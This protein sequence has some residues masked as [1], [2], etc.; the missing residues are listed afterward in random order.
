[1]TSAKPQPMAGQTEAPDDLIAELARLM[2][3]D[4]RPEA[5]EPA[6]VRI[7]GSEAAPQAQPP[8]RIPGADQ[9]SAAPARAGDDT[10][11]F[12]FD[13]DLGA[14]R[15]PAGPVTPLPPA[16][17]MPQAPETAE[18]PADAHDSIADL[19]AAEFASDAGP[20]IEPE[21]PVAPARGEDN[22]GVPPVFGLGTP[23]PA[24]P[25]EPVIAEPVVETP[26]PAEAPQAPVERSDSLDEIER[27]VGPAVRL[28]P[29]PPSPALRSLATPTL[30]REPT[31]HQPE[32]RHP[33]HAV[34][35]AILAAAAATGAAVDYV[36]T[37]SA[38]PAAFDGDDVPP[39]AA[40]RI[41]GLSRGFAG[42]LV[43]VTLLV[44]A[45][46]GLYWVL[47]NSGGASGPAPLIVANAEPVKEV[48]EMASDEAAPQSVVFNEISGVD[49]G[50]DERIV[51]RDQADVAAVSQVAA[52][53]GGDDGLV[54]R[55]VRTVTVRPD[56][57]IVSGEEGLAGAAMLPV[58][59]PDVPDVPGA[60]FS[61][62]D[63]L[64][65]AETPAETPAATAAAP[66][67]MVPV[68][69]GSTVPAVDAAGNPIAGR[70][71]PVP[72]DKPADYAQL[73]AALEQRQPILAQ[74][75][76]AQQPQ[77]GAA[78]IATA[79]ADTAPAYVQLSSQ[80][81]E[82]AARQSAENIARRYGVLFGG[83][84]LEVQRVD[85]GERGIFYRVRVP[86][87]SLES[88]NNICT[89]VKAAGGDCF[90]M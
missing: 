15:R 55:K 33:D 42:P 60:D 88:A 52:L 76:P 31:P 58:D 77:P 75:A 18:T 45:G 16:A 73:V 79:G 22:F 70:T 20:S 65:S 82:E 29:A 46:L 7:P 54:N 11:S 34:E 78:P 37:E 41:F 27:L 23:A 83:A 68:T 4:A 30:P 84:N 17:P 67:D 19:I 8:I 85:L 44:V 49:T 50:A 24:R 13:F 86:A 36:E 56:G 40:G 62:P 57:T 66:A 1:M 43:A 81:S 69:P 32:A 14:E 90:T 9:P 39:R 6:P 10:P 2:A 71:A 51:S 80:R 12:A 89:N 48:P 59:R 26:A 64:A 3:E 72:L 35:D 47:G 38:G 61:T 53:D 5:P 21:E 25:V 63:L 28:E 87:N 74:P